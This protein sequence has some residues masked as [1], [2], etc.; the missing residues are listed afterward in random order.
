MWENALTDK[1]LESLSTCPKLK[2][3]GIAETWLTWNGGL[4]YLAKLKGQLTDLDL[5]N[6]IIEPAD[7]E[8]LKKEMPNTK[9][10][11]KGLEAG[12]D[13]ISKP[14]IRPKAEK[15]IPKELLDRVMA[16]PKP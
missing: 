5:G 12:K 9:I 15:W 1:T 3:F 4:Q 2:K 10:L 6:C 13:E 7:V 8:R 11:W 16:G 14:W